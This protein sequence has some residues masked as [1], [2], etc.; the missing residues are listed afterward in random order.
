[1]S[2]LENKLRVH[3]T[4]RDRARLAPHL[5]GWNHLQEVL[6][7]EEFSLDEIKMLVLIEAEGQCRQTI[8]DRLLARMKKMER[9]ELVAAIMKRGRERRAGKTT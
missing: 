4:A 5:A 8:M 7:L 9:K 3:V 2:E 6:L 1:M